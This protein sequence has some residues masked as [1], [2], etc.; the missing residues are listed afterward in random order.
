MMSWQERETGM[1]GGRALLIAL[2]GT[3]GTVAC[4]H[5]WSAAADDAGGTDVGISDGDAA[6]ESVGEV[7]EEAEAVAEAE[8]DGEADAPH[9][10]RPDVPPVCGNGIL[11]PGEACDDGNTDTE[12]CGGDL[13]DSCLS[14]C[15]LALWA[16]GN[17]RLD[18]GEAC[19]D[20]NPDSFDDCTTSCT[21]NDRSIG[22]PCRCVNG[23]SD[24]DFSA[25]VIEGCQAVPEPADTIARVACYRALSGHGFPLQVH[26]A[27]GYCTW[28]AVSCEGPEAICSMVPRYGDPDLLDCPDGYVVRSFSG[29][30]V[31]A[32]ITVAY[33]AKSC[34]SQR[35]CRWN[36]VE[37]ESSP[38]A[39]QCGQWTCMTDEAA[40]PLFCDDPRNG[41]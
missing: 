5:D 39:G 19:D 35:D 3:V 25:G 36:A 1:G 11:E 23:C 41:V 8:G 14:D 20:G 29:E 27:E 21:A 33:C 12:W 38:W 26:A 18:P 13:E 37:D 6:G 24:L 30:A 34:S 32:I 16:C 31:G 9:D 28:M 2:W 22:A 7:S 4:G 40:G 10:A 15:S 17:G